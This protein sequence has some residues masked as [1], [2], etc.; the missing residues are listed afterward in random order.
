LKEFYTGLDPMELDFARQLEHIQAVDA[1]EHLFSEEIRLQMR[2]DVFTQFNHYCRG[3]LEAAGMTAE[4]LHFV[5]NS[6]TSI[7]GRWARLKPYN[8]HIRDTAYWRS[9]HITLEH[10]YGANE[11]NDQTVETV[12]EAIQDANRPGLHQRL[13]GEAY[14]LK[15]YLTQV[16]DRSADGLLT[17]VYR[18]QNRLHSREDVLAF[19]SILNR[20]ISSL[21]DLIYAASVIIEKIKARGDVGFKMTVFPMRK[22]HLAMAGELFASIRSGQ[23]SELPRQNPIS[24]VFYD[25]TFRCL[26]KADITAAVHAGYLGDFR[27]LNPTHA[28]WILDN[29][30]NVRFDLY[31]L[32]YPYARESIILGKSRPNVWLNLCWTSIISE[33]FAYESLVEIQDMVPTNKI[34]GFGG[35]FAIAEKVFGHLTLTRQTISRALCARIRAGPLTFGRAV[36]LADK[37]LRVNPTELYQL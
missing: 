16:A 7:G 23:V 3:D 24:D 4:D 20:E 29:Y 35:D 6:D 13:L 14:N 22:P 2:V 5:F 27:D 9:A 36:N 1:H 12:T 10:F 19:S 34:I 8:A 17:P 28:I 37:I 26:A 33:K 18:S 31:H 11:L 30:T 21:D 25:T 15:T 32:G